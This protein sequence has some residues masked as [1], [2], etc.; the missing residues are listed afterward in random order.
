MEAACRFLHC[1]EGVVPF[2]YLGLS[3]GANSRKVP[4]WEPMLDQL[5]K[6][7]NSWGNK[8]VSLGGRIAL[9][10]SVLNAIPIFYLSFLKI[11]VKV[12]KMMIRIQR[13]FHWGGVKGGRKV[14]W[15]QWRKVCQ[16]KSKEGLG[17][18]DV[19]L[20]NLS[21]L[22]KWKWR[23]LQEE[24]PLWKRVLVDKYG[25]HVSGLVPSEGAR[26]SRF[27][28]LWWRNLMSLEVGEG[29]NW[30]TMRVR[31]KIGNGM[32]TTFWKDM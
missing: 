18:R 9:L 30:F 32:N 24:Q 31:R 21:L 1:R 14:C 10:N 25:D 22:A 20:V 12:L 28:S 23:L 3:V 27:T 19:K 11:L 17:V 2:K 16:P 26:W 6:R 13:E 8:Y 7:L 15:V 5:K 29:P 4:T